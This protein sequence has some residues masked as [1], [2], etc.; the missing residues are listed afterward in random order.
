MTER[1]GAVIKGWFGFRVFAGAVRTT[2]PLIPR[3][4]RYDRRVYRK[5]RAAGKGL[6]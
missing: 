3:P 1:Q 2:W 5:I 4:L 6:S